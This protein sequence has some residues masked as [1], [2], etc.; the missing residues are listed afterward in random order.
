MLLTQKSLEGLWLK[1]LLLVLFGYAVLGKGFA[2]LFIG[3]TILVLGF[4]VY[5]LSQRVSLVFSDSILLLLAI[6]AFRGFCRTVPFLS[7]Y[8]F[9][10]V[11]DAVQ[12]GYG[13]A[14][15]PIVSFTN[16]SS[17]ISRGLNTYRKFLRWYLPC[18]PFLLFI[19]TRFG[20]SIPPVPGTTVGILHLKTGD[21]AVQLAASALFLLI[22][23]DRQSS[24]EK[25]NRPCHE[26]AVLVSVLNRGGLLAIAV[27]I[28]IVSVLRIKKIGWKVAALTV[29]G[30]L[31]LVV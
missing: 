29:T 1:A 9:D 20:D 3:E 7:K 21:A 18:L 6:F 5:L 24:L 27:P 12:W 30:V 26:S 8:R 22:F 31:L 10:A 17:Q 23:S 11:R 19:S 25:H 13:L 16:R 14:T 28:I 2:Y 4:I 15:L